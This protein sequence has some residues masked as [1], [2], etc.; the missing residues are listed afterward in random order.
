MCTIFWTKMTQFVLNKNFL[1]QTIIINSIYLLALFIVQNL[2]KFL[3][4]IQNYGDA[5]F[6]APKLCICLKLILFWKII[7]MILI[8][9]LAPFI[10]QNLK[11]IVPADPELWGC[12]IF[13]S[14]M[15]H[16]PKQEFFKKTCSRAL[17]LLFI[18]IYMPKIKVR[19]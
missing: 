6:L 13:R 4:R 12:A 2:K 7:T 17:F 19:Y 3:Q 15:A 8:Y 16:F 9:L 18:P 1:V 14:K 10:V 5:P 11:K